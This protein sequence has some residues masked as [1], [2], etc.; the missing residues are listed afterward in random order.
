MGF[1]L[2]SWGK[3]KSEAGNYFQNNVWMWRPLAQYVI[4]QTKCVDEFDVEKLRYHR[5]IIMTDADVDGSHI[6]TLLLTFFY[7]QI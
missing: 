4:E 5:V 3:A 1:D 2:Q 6:R 7:N